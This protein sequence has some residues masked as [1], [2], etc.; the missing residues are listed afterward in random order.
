MVEALLLGDRIAVMESGRLV[1]IGRPHTLLTEPA[2][3]YV[4]RLME[5]PQRQTEQL[6]ALVTGDDPA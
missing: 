4:A 5:T 2:T 1:Q 6:E 3:D